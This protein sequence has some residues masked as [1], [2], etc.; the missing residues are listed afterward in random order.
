MRGVEDGSVK[1]SVTIFNGFLLTSVDISNGLYT[2][3]L[4]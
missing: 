3:L 4:Y 1:N 2:V